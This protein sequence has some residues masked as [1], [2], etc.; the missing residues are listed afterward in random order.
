MSFIAHHDQLMGLSNRGLLKD[1]HSLTVLLQHIVFR[2][3]VL[4]H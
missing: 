2:S 1:R 3:E 4:G